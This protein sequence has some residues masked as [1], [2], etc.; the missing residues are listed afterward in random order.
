MLVVITTIPFIPTGYSS[1]LA[2]ASAYVGID[3]H[4]VGSSGSG[5][6]VKFSL[7]GTLNVVTTG[8]VPVPKPPLKLALAV[9]S[10]AYRGD[11]LITVI[12]DSI[13]SLP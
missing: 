3:S 9:M 10:G 8:V 13:K 2:K 4:S 1:G 7:F 6:Y 11:F 5:K 12:S